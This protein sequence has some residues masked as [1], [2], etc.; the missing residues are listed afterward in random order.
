MKEIKAVKIEDL[1]NSDAQLAE[2]DTEAFIKLPPPYED[3]VDEPVQELTDEQKGRLEATLDGVISIQMPKPGS[4][5]TN[6]VVLINMA[7]LGG[8]GSK[9]LKP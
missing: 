6:G 5:E 7:S 2:L 3:W 8:L 4:Q 1:S 9:A